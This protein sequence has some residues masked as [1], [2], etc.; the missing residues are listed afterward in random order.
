MVY[1]LEPK[2][3]DTKLFR[4]PHSGSKLPYLTVKE[5]RNRYP[6][7]NFTV[8]GE[9]GCIMRPSNGEDRLFITDGKL[10]PILPRGSI[11]RPFEWVAGFVPVN[12]NAYVAAIRSPIAVFTHI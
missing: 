9:I 6:D 8:I 3:C 4:E 11:K 5:M 1:W 12:T 7:G 10:I 2:V